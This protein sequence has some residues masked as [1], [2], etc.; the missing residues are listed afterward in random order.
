MRLSVE[1]IHVLLAKGSLLVTAA[2]MVASI[3]MVAVGCDAG[4]PWMQV[5]SECTSLY[6]RWVV[7]ESLGMLVEIF[8]LVLIVRIYVPLQIH[9][10]AK[11]RGL[12]TFG[13]RM[14]IVVFVAYRLA[15]LR[16]LHTSSNPPFAQVEIIAWTQAELAFSL[17]T[18]TLPC[19]LAFMGQLN[20][21]WG[22]M[23]SQAV[24]AQSQNHSQKTGGGGYEMRSFLSGN[25]K[26]LRSHKSML[27]SEPSHKWTISAPQEGRR[28]LGSD[29]S[30]GMIIRRTVEFSST[31]E[32]QRPVPR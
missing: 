7:I 15:S 25:G 9:W 14:M 31:T 5:E 30:T 22:T 32:P 16:D 13:L 10:R 28:S 3:V 18:A 1:R 29:D 24:I 2:A 23:N 6:D 20:S 12:S 17:I 21:G 11:V 4:R 8:S 27:T 19:L 26:D